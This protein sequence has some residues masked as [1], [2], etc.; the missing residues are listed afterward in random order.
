[1]TTTAGPLL[2]QPQFAAQIRSLPSPLGVPI[3]IQRGFMIWE[4]GSA[5]K[6]GSNLGYTGG[7]YKDGRDKIN[8]L[9]NPA[10]V[11]SQYAV[12]N[13]TLQSAMMYPVPGSTSAYLAPLQQT[14]AWD[15]YFDRTF[16]VNYGTGKNGSGTGQP[17]DPA[18]IGAQADVLQFMQFTGVLYRGGY[19]AD[20]LIG[21]SGGQSATGTQISGGRT[22]GSVTGGGIM[23]MMPCYVY[24]GNAQ[25]SLD[26]GAIQ[27]ASWGATGTQ[28]MY[29]GYISS[30]SVNYTHWS[31]NMVPLRCVIS[32]S[33]TMLPNPSA[34][35]QSSVTNDI[36]PWNAAPSA[37]PNYTRT[38]T[39]IGG[40]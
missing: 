24:F 29:F 35:D 30:F 8:F 10:T 33:F 31:N 1:M 12:G 21:G 34:A 38:T 9:Y 28:L 14:V 40:R 4:Y 18:V 22:S 13:G 15:L 7:P 37:T 11:S 2:V 19:D 16:E 3:N 27:S 5:S 32:V 6:D 26:T 39:G 23:M 20:L 17:N 25:Q 36:S